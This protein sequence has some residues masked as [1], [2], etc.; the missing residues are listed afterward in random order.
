MATTENNY[1]THGLRGQVGGLFVFKT[2]NGKTIVAAPPR[3]SHHEPT[4]KQL[5]QQNLFQEA[6]IYGKTVMVT[7]KLSALYKTAV[8]QGGSVYKVALADF[9]N[10]PKINEID[11][12]NYVGNPGNTIRIRA[13][14][15]FMVANVEVTIYN[16]EGSIVESGQAIKEANGVDWLFTVT[17]KNDSL[18]G[19]KIVVRAFDI[20]GNVTILD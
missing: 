11:V 12:S 5:K 20:T 2:V 13:I 3:K 8:P 15:D 9:L 7:P 6:A 4:E 16:V 10:A 18:T 1:V 17:V 14:D 19:D